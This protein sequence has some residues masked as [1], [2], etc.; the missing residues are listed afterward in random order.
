[1][2]IIYLTGASV[3]GDSPESVHTVETASKLVELGHRVEIV[4]HRES[5]Q[6]YK[7]VIGGVKIVRAHMKSKGRLI[8]VIATRRLTH[9][10]RRRADVIIESYHALGGLGALLSFLKD[11]PLVLEVDAPG[12]HAALAGRPRP[13]LII[14][15]ALKLWNRI[16]FASAAAIITS[17]DT[18]VPEIYGP[19]AATGVWGVNTERFCLD[20]TR[21]S[22]TEHIRHRFDMRGHKVV[23]FYGDLDEAHGAKSLSEIFDHIHDSAPGIRFLIVGRGPLRKGL[24]AEFQRRSMAEIVT[25]ADEP[26]LHEKPYWLA[27]ID[28]AVAPY[29]PLAGPLREFGVYWPLTQL[30]QLMACGTAVVSYDFKSARDAFADERGVLVPGGSVEEMAE[31][32]AALADD[33]ERTR[34]IGRK[35]GEFAEAN[36]D[37]SLCAKKLEYIL[38]QAIANPRPRFKL[39]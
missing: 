26:P 4:V 36:L 1:L 31:T 19:K 13:H 28:V 15:E 24:E 34:T 12:L 5:G 8:P 16:Q 10:I 22:M 9:F 17:S 7:E 37:V 23:G 11:V 39:F 2:R 6:S 25:F 14:D 30:Y 35:A 18:L 32:V 20:L 29:S 3:P 33:E 38:Q 21:S 27:A